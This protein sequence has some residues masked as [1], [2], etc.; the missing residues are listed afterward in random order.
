MSSTNYFAYETVAQRYARHRPYFH[1]RLIERIRRRLNLDEPVESALDVGCGTGQSTVALMALAREVIGADI[2]APMLA[3][4]WQAATATDSLQ[5]NSNAT[6]NTSL[7]LSR[8]VLKGYLPDGSGARLLTLGR[9]TTTISETATSFV[10]GQVQS[11]T[12]SFVADGNSTGFGGLGLTLTTHTTGGAA[13]PGNTYVVRTTGTPVYG[14][15]PTTGA[16]AG[17]TSRS[18]RRQYR[19]VPTID[20]GLNM[21]MVFAYSPSTAELNGIPAANLQLFSRPI[22]GGVWRP[23]G[24]SNSAN[25]VTL[26]GLTHLSDW[27]L[28][29]KAAPLPVTLTRFDAERQGQQALLTWATASEHNSKGFNVQVST[30]SREF[31]TAGF[32]PSASA[33][34]TQAQDYRFVEA[35]V[36]AT[37]TRYYR[38]QQLDLDGS[39]TY[40]AVRSLTFGTAAAL[41]ASPNPFSDVLYLSTSATEATRTTAVF[42]DAAGRT[43]GKQVL[44]VPAGAAQLTLGGL[45]QLPKGFYVL[46][47]TLDNQPH[48]LK[49]VK[50]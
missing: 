4:A 30:D 9:T 3:A 40:T 1:P 34:S 2:S 23:E 31:R 26:T 45:G 16:N 28:G 42:T 11:A 24:G 37:G 14:A 32:V 12:L 44:D 33:N 15:T 46:R 25:T 18:I 27:T 10:L 50:E 8:G 29:N 35:P 49:V 21:D 6:I 20:T 43:V 41:E 19:V 17:I 5:L 22:T 39:S 38:L 7:V 13:L 47:F 48:Y 36:N